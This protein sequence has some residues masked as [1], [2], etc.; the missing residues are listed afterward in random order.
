M[1]FLALIL[2]LT[3]TVLVSSEV[4]KV[5]IYDDY[6]LTYMENGTAKG[7]FV[8]LLNYIAKK[9]EWK[10]KY[11]Y[12][13][14]EDLIKKLE[15]GDIDA[16]TPIADT[17]E[18]RLKFIFNGEAILANWG[19]VISRSKVESVFE[20]SGK[21]AALVKDDVY[22]FGFLNL[23]NSFDVK[24]QKIIWAPTYDEAIELLHEG[25]TDFAIVSRIAATVRKEKYHYRISP[26]VFSPV[27]L[28]IAFSKYSPHAEYYAARIDEN[29]RSLKS[30]SKSIYWKLI[31]RYLV[32]SAEIPRER[33][34]LVI[35][36]ILGV[37]FFFI[38]YLFIQLR[39]K[40]REL[41]VSNENLR[42]AN[43][44]IYVMNEH[45][46][47]I[48]RELQKVFE[49]FQEVMELISEMSTFTISEEEFLTKVLQLALK[50]V[51][52]AKC[53]SVS[54]IEGDRWRYV[55]AVGHDIELLK[56]LIEL[57]KQK[58]HYFHLKVF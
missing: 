20:L 42:S 46:Q 12:G 13:E 57:S 26:I 7:L 32:I 38:L 30:D 39:K 45:I 9:E 44:Q 27:E 21:T 55:A 3:A 54:V 18:R 23:V 28:K 50:L 22:A 36:I 51:P 1:R 24:L 17:P 40:R 49:R 8:D 5:G 33:L 52:K 48:Y 53:G 29:L 35:S 16:I 14:W 25:K 43:E 37:I 15:N 31:D 6:P 10:I 2:V 47:K 56:K 19:V 4:I 41:E 34:F 11:V 58:I